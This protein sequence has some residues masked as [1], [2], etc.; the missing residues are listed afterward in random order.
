MLKQRPSQDFIE[1]VPYATTIDRIELGTRVDRLMALQGSA[2]ALEAPSMSTD[3]L[4][5]THLPDTSRK[6]LTD[7]GRDAQ[8]RSGDSIKDDSIGKR[9]RAEESTTRSANKKKDLMDEIF[10]F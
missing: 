7:L 2:A 5:E 3:S 9:A 6:R 8:W 1:R 10:G 4:V